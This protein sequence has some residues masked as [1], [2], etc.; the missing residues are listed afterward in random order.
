[1]VSTSIDSKNLHKLLQIQQARL[2]VEEKKLK[3]AQDKYNRERK[4]LEERQDKI[5]VINKQT[6]N[7][8]N[9][10]SLEKN[11]CSPDNINRANSHQ[12]WLRYDL[13]M[14]QF[15]LSQEKESVEN[16]KKEYEKTRQIWMKQK[17]KTDKLEEM[18]INKRNTENAIK[19]EIEDENDFDDRVDIGHMAYGKN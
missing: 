19:E 16:A 13:E 9:Y 7:V 6:Q 12:F 5:N 2:T 17:L 3:E 11:Y 15:Y 1:M 10:K 4:Q 18:Y 14:H 8:K